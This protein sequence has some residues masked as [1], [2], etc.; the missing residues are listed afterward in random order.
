MYKKILLSVFVLFSMSSS[1]VAESIPYVGVK[2]ALDT[3]SWDFH[4]PAGDTFHFGSSGEALGIF[5]GLSA[6]LAQRYY[7]AGEVFVNDS[8]TKTANKI[9]DGNGT[10][11][12]LRTTYSYGLSFIPGFKVSADTLLYLR[13]GVVRTEF[14]LSQLPG[15][16]Q[17]SVASG[18]QAGVGLALSLGKNLDLR[19]EYTY[20]AYMTFSSLGNMV[21]PR[22]NELSVGFVYKIV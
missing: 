9:I 22:S 11:A 4:N 10:T 2:L 17:S 12:K 13:G 5:G 20:G 19:G 7:F 16:R 18:G 15:G 14:E 8:S 6:T 1:V 21:S 3:G